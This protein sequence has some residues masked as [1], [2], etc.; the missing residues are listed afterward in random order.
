MV[1]SLGHC[2]SVLNYTLS[3]AIFIPYGRH[4][5]TSPVP[6]L[7][8][9]YWLVTWKCTEK[10][11]DGTELGASIVT[12]W[13]L[14]PI[15][16]ISPLCCNL[17]TYF[18]QC[19]SKWVESWLFCILVL[20]KHD[21]IVATLQHGIQSYPNLRSKTKVTQMWVQNKLEPLP[22]EVRVVFPYGVVSH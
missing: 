16:Q 8:S 22:W 20:Q 3:C 1:E 7:T 4:A 18:L 2:S 17:Q 6:D 21:K 11:M 5:L 9:C 10:T 19:V 13:Q 14:R 15:A 12:R